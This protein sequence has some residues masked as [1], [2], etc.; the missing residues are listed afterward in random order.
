MAEYDLSTFKSLVA[1]DI[2]SYH[3]RRQRLDATLSASGSFVSRLRASERGKS[4]RKKLPCLRPVQPIEELERR[5]S[6]DADLL[7]LKLR[8][9]R[10]CGMHKLCSSNRCG[11]DVRDGI[12]TD[13]EAT[14]LVA[15]GQG[16]LDSEGAAAR[17]VGWPYLRVEFMRSARNGSAAGHVLM[18]RAAERLRRVVAEVFELPLSRVGHA[19][20]LLALRRTPMSGAATT[21]EAPFE[22]E[23]LYHVDES[24]SPFF[25]F[26]SVVWLSEQGRDFDGGELVFL[27]NRT[28]PWLVVEPAVGRTAFFSSGWENVHGI[29]PLTRGQRWALS[30]VF[31]VN[32]D[33]R[34]GAGGAAQGG[35]GDGEVELEAARAGLGQQFR[36]LCVR[37]ADKSHYAPCRE[38]WAASLS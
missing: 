22:E 2:A 17:D 28:W 6:F 37:P 19:E 9:G 15:H 8:R 11:I 24:L 38:S 32:D 16:V 7:A 20:T 34:R 26:S 29:K 23:S 36:E 27:H 1:D 30:M 33:P 3:E 35:A 25:H 10:A 14:A 21:A 13:E 18:M 31:W 4:Y 12:L 5:H